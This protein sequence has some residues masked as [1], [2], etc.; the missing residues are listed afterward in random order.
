MERQRAYLSRG[1]KINLF[2]PESIRKEL[3]SE[4]EHR[5]LSVSAVVREALRQRY[6]QRSTTK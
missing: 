4:A 1:P 5:M 6:E 3:E 2:V